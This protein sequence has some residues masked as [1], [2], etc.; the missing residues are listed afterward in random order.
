MK[1]P[2]WTLKNFSSPEFAAQEESTSKAV[3]NNRSSFIKAS[4]IIVVDDAKVLSTITAN[5]YLFAKLWYFLSNSDNHLV[6]LEH[7]AELFGSDASA[8]LEDTVEVGKIV[9]AALKTDFRYVLSG[10]H[11]HPRREA[12]PY[13][14]HII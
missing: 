13:V 10:V 12:Q 7:G 1:H 3:K 8:A 2:S 4:S 9:E 14:Q 11:E 5:K 6:F